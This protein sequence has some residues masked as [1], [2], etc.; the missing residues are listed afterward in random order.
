[1]GATIVDLPVRGPYVFKVKGQTYYK[2]SHLQPL[3][4][5]APQSAQLYVIDSTQA[6][7]IVYD[8]IFQM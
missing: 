4:N 3:N 7:D 8:E 1:M 6:T 2:T 5:Q